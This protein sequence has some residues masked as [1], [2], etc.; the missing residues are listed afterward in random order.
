MTDKG[1][2]VGEYSEFFKTSGTFFTH[3][4][5]ISDGEMAVPN[6]GSVLSVA[7]LAVLVFNDVKF[8]L[9][10]MFPIYSVTL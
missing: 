5:N 7:S 6:C 4:I 8:S 2:V 1:I 9:Y 10:F 3:K